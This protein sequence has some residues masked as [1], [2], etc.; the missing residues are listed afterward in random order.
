MHLRFAG[1]CIEL[2]PKSR[3]W[4]HP[5][6][7]VET[8]RRHSHVRSPML[9]C[10]STPAVSDGWPATAVLLVAG[11]L[12]PPR[13]EVG[14]TTHHLDPRQSCG[15]FVCWVFARAWRAK[16]SLARLAGKV[17]YIYTCNQI[18]GNILWMFWQWWK[19]CW[20]QVM[21]HTNSYKFHTVYGLFRHIGFRPSWKTKLT[22]EPTIQIFGTYVCTHIYTYMYVCMSYPRQNDQRYTKAQVPNTPRSISANW[23]MQR[24]KVRD[25]QQT[26]KVAFVIY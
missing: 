3:T 12:H 21:H 7:L 10:R 13:S 22:F 11:L 4:H 18:F 8:G 1:C 25:K 19:S 24:G 5:N 14:A 20:I 23:W 26:N 15:F 9:W 16:L 2:L 6:N 17:L